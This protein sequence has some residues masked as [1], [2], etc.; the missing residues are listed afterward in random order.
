MSL[1]DEFPH[2]FWEPSRDGLERLRPIAEEDLES[3]VDKLRGMGLVDEARKYPKGKIIKAGQ[4]IMTRLLTAALGNAA[5]EMAFIWHRFAFAGCFI[6]KA[7]PEA[8]GEPLQF[9][10]LYKRLKQRFR[11]IRG[12]LIWTDAY[13]V[14]CP[15]FRMALCLLYTYSQGWAYNL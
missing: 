13:V 5:R 3:Y 1:Q 11:E 8:V 14:F 2:L 12:Q 4:H 6:E 7:V 15:N 9:L 10:T